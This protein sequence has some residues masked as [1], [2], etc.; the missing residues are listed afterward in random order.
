M[1]IWEKKKIPQNINRN[2]FYVGDFSEYFF[3]VLLCIFK[4]LYNEHMVIRKYKQY[5]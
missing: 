5:F 2:Y 4:I 1:N 3:F